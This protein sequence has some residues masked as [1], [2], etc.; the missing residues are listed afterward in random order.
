[1]ITWLVDTGPLVV[2]LDADDRAHARVAAR[3]D[4]FAGQLV[5]TSS[6]ITETMH[7]VAADPTGP[8]QLADLVETS[9]M[10]VYDLTRPPELGEA[11]ALMQKYGD[12][13]M[14]FAD[15]T[16]VLLAEALRV[17]DVLTLDFRGFTVYRTRKGR[18]L[19][20]VLGRT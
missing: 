17:P 8:R 16:L 6:V 4:G 10:E 15:A 3:W 20:L 13:P 18:P 9:G 11:A 19:G 5:T 12:T 7:F 14:D 1:V 2:Y